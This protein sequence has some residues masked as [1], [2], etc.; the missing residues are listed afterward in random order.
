MHEKE[1]IVFCWSGGKDSAMALH[2][3]LRGRQY[4]VVALLTSVAEQ[5][6]R[7]S[8]HGVRV[9]LLERQAEAIGIPLDKLYLP[10][11]PQQPCTNE[12]Y[13]ELMERT[14]LRYRDRGVN[15]VGFGDIFLQ[16]LREY[17]ERNLAKVGMRAMFPIWGRSTTELA[18]HCIRTGFRAYLSCVEDKL[19]RPFAGRAFDQSLLEDLPIGIDTCGEYGEYHTFVYDGPIFRCP[20]A[21]ELGEIVTR[22]GRHYAD[23][24]PV[25]MVTADAVAESMP[26][27]C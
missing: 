10:S 25:E 8:H 2:E 23:L 5:Y 21:V 22:D 20:V 6:E 18:D 16:D 1:K 19:G 12:V 4:E 9:E 7:V 11:G 26:P 24:L 14:M 15:T 27:V 17:R 13:E 3:I